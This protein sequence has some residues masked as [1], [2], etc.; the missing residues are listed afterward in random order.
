[1][2]KLL[3]LTVVLVMALVSVS[4]LAEA[5]TL[6]VGI[7]PEFPPFE[8]LDDAGNVIGFDADLAAEISKDI[9]A[10]LEF[11]STSF[12]SIVTGV[13]TGLYD[14]GISGIYITEERLANVDFSAPYLQDRQSCIVKVS[15]TSITDNASLMGKK[16]GS[17]AGTT[18]IDAAE[19]STDESNV[20]SYTK[21]L[22]AV[23]D[24]QGGKLDAVITD[25]PVAKLL[26][27]QLNDANLTISPTVTFDV[28]YYGIAIPKGNTDLKTKIDASIQRMTDD[29]TI[30][31]LVEKWGITS[32][33]VEAAQ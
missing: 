14:L 3:A 26:L 32:G 4:A 6:K 20:Y 1:M 9:G 7:N 19:A 25:T 2:K 15:D 21:A 30:A 31:A 8:S 13:Q 11:E 27:A 28:E 22:D 24:L 23:M 33:L 29:G 10:T 5:T 16:I 18:G 12:D 17:Q